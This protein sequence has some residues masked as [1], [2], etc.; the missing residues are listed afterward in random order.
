MLATGS[1]SGDGDEATHGNGDAKLLLRGGYVFVWSVAV[2]V[3]I[4]RSGIWIIL[5]EWSPWNCR[6]VREWLDG[7]GAVGRASDVYHCNN[8]KVAH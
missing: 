4:A 5:V 8:L 1:E 7:D 6:L 3:S 2:Q